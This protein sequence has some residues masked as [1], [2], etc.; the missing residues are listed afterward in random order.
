MAAIVVHPF[1]RERT[2]YDADVKDMLLRTL[3]IG[4]A[5]TDD[6]DLI[7]RKRTAVAT[8]YAVMAAG[9]PYAV[10]GLMADRPVVVA[11]A[12]FQIAGQVINLVIFSRTKRLAPMV[13][14]LTALGLLTIFSGVLT[15]G[16]LANG[17]GNVIYAI[18]APIGVV[19][20][21]GS[22]AGW[23]AYGALV[24]LVVVGV[25]LDPLIPDDQAL[26]HGATLVLLSANLL[27]TAAIAL[28]VV[29]YIDGERQA[30]RRQSDAL[31]LNVLPEA[32]AVRLKAGERVIADHYTEASVLFADIVG[33]TPM[34]EVRS[35][36]AVVGILNELFTEFDRLAEQFGLEKIKT[37][38]DAYMVVAGVPEPRD[39]HAQVIMEMALAMHA[40]TAGLTTEEGRPLQIRVGISSGPLVAG[41]IGEKKFSYDL[42]GDTV[43][44]AARMESSGIAGCIQLTDATHDLL[45]DRYPFVHRD[46]LD[47]KG[48]GPMSTWTLDPATME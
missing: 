12:I 7:V 6:P 38:G 25:V 22:R 10:L 29:Q 32:I 9:V 31:L 20:L 8:V 33:F 16:G 2:S 42:W 23:P 44:T 4:T 41:V 18:L 24:A 14:T 37:I 35:P 3:D 26:P 45:A 5:P 34:A 48:K 28:V 15:L 36:Q 27:G 17:S 30:A 46:G 40:R 21:I 39:D 13:V 43:N 47:V 1:R 11:F 19:L